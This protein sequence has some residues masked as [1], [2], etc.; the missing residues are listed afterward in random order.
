MYSRLVTRTFH[1]RKQI[2][3]LETDHSD[4]RPLLDSLMDKRRHFED[5]EKLLE[6]ISKNPNGIKI[7]NEL[8]GVKQQLID[9]HY[10]KYSDL[11]QIGRYEINKDKFPQLVDPNN[12]GTEPYNY[13][14]ANVNITFKPKFKSKPKVFVA[15]ATIDSSKDA[16]T[17][18]ELFLDESSI[19]QDG[20][21][22]ILKTW[23]QSKVYKVDVVWIAFGK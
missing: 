19:T 12:Y 2:P 21:E 4:L 22:A 13:R 11:I 9:N 8:E 7:I 10:S 15:L 16:N 23:D 14:E 20:F 18:I 3:K 5:A 1:L 17:R 6:T